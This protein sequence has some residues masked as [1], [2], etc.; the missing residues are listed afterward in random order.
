MWLNHGRWQEVQQLAAQLQADPRT[1]IDGALLKAR[2]LMVR[3]EFPAAR[4]LIEETIARAPKA[5]WPRELL[6]HMLL[7]EGRDMPALVQALR[8]VLAL[9]PTN[10][11]A[12]QNLPIALQKI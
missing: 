7:M 6:A 11:F 4:K 8:D 1:S 12:L 9:D 5:Q 3:K 2:S 10:N